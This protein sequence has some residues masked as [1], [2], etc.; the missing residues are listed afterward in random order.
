M[1]SPALIASSATSTRFIPTKPTLSWTAFGQVT[2]SNFNSNLAYSLSVD[3]GTATRSGSVVSL[4]S[5]NAIVT[6]TSS[7][8]KGGTSTASTFERRAYTFTTTNVQSCTDN[9]ASAYSWPGNCPGPNCCDA[10]N[11]CWGGGVDGYCAADGTICCGGSRGQT[12]TTNT[13]TTKNATPDGFTDQ[14]GEWGRVT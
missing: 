3:S 9:C 6:I 10:N 14:Y 13:I 5:I 8:P 12:C 11:N 7:S 4:S 2:I 1:I